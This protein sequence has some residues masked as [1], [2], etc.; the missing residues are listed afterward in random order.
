MKIN[1][2]LLFILIAPLVVCS[3]GENNQLFLY[4]LQC[5][6]LDNPLAIDSATPRFSWKISS[7][8]QNVVQEYYEIQVASTQKALRC[9]DANLWQS[10][11][12]ASDASVL[13]PYQGVAL[14]SRDM[15]YWRVRVWDNKGNVSKWSEIQ[16]FGIGILSAEEWHGEYIGIKDCKVPQLRRKFDVKD[17]STTRLLHINSLGYHEIYLN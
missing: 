8:Q 11:K 4:D 7:Q 12:V 9:G 1:R 15:A 17:K 16:R 5:E 6:N 14:Q 3:C 10:G 13:V 2:L